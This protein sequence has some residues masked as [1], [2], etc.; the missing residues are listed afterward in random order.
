MKIKLPNLKTIGIFALVFS[1][2]M[3]F[4][5][6]P[7]SGNL[8]FAEND[9]PG[10]LIRI[11][12]TSFSIFLIWYSFKQR[13]KFVESSEV[14]GL[15]VFISVDVFKT[16]INRIIENFDNVS[17]HDISVS[18]TELEGV[19]ELVVEI[20]TSDPFSISEVI[21]EISDKIKLT[22]ESSIGETMALRVTIK[23]RSFEVR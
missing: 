10:I 13:E 4:S 2:G 23:V 14:D 5:S 20:S 8:I 11:L 15:N 22:I 3:W 19:R 1:A 18:K 9:L 12:V 7:V 17:L 21:K 16:L 6:I